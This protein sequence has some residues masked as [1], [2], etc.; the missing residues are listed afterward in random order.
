MKTLRL[1][2]LV[3]FVCSIFSTASF[4]LPNSERNTPE[5]ISVEELAK[6]PAEEIPTALSKKEARQA[7]KLDK[8]MARFKKRLEKFD[9]AVADE[10]KT[11][12]IIAYITIIGFLVSLLALH[13]KGDEFS[14][15]HLRQALGIG[16]TSVVLSL[17]A[18]LLLII[19]IVGAIALLAISIML[20]IAW[21]SGLV[22]A[23]N[24]K[25][26]PVFLFGE[27]FQQ[28]FSGIE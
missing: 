14:A 4:A 23:I 11:A 9:K 15:F 28:W 17:I 25:Q 26:K 2:L 3:V 22:S 13:K 5:S 7:K 21:I 20:L 27:K 24:G 8:K 18:G 1:T 12:A 10:S 19:P 16:L 6:A